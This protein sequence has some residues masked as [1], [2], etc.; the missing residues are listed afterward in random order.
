MK[1]ALDETPTIGALF[2]RY[3]PVIRSRVS[4]GT[5]RGYA[6]AWRRRVAPL[7]AELPITELTPLEV[8]RAWALWDGKRSTKV[9]AL[10]ML[11]HIC[12][13][14]IKG[15]LIESN[16]CAAVDLPRVQADDP[17]SRAL[18][19]SEV[20]RLLELLPAS[21]PYRRFVL[22]ML[23]TGCRLGEVAGLRVSDVDWETRTISVVRTASAGLHGEVVIGPTKSR[24]SRLVPIPDQL[25]PVLE[26]AIAGKGQHDP[27]FPGPRGG[28]MNSQNLSRALKWQSIR[29][30]IKTF[31]PG[32]PPLH[33]HDLRHTAVTLMFRSGMSAPDVQA[34]AGHSSLQVTQRYADT[35]RDAARRATEALS[36]LFTPLGLSVGEGGEAEKRASDLDF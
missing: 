21:G 15:R 9:D 7:F 33:W 14:A 22:A 23:F 17:A 10:S 34:V 35:R 3:W 16:P 19:L 24:R 29:D 12:Q 1:L 26:D 18:D 31:P 25:V 6:T 28:V 27:L 11:S 8:E 13:V 30:R 36:S 5:A 4:P 32:E 20:A 2:E